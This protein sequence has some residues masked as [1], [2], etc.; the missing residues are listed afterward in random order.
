MQLSGS[1][2]KLSGLG[3]VGPA[4]IDAGM[5]TP[6]VPNHQVCC[7]DDHISGNGLSVCS[8]EKAMENNKGRPQIIQMGKKRRLALRKVEIIS[9]AFSCLRNSTKERGSSLNSRGFDL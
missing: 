7:E 9:R 2:D 4:D 6:R 1:V 5:V 8:K 3:L